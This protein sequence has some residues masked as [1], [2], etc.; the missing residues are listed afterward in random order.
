MDHIVWMDADRYTHTD[1]ESIP[2]GECREVKGTPMD[3]TTPKALSKDTD[4]DYDQLKWA[5]GFDHNYC[6]NHHTLDK[7]SCTL[8]STQS[9][10]KMEVYT[11]LPG[12]Q[13]YAGNYLDTSHIG[14]GGC[15]YDKRHGVC[16][17]SQYFPNAIN[18]PEFDQPIAK[19]GVKAHSSTIYKFV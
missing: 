10:R 12:M 14:K 5:G 1:S 3:F 6:L 4:A 11:D 2:H 19:A 9:G 8:E 13:L 17:E 18:V 16:F 15:V 7:P